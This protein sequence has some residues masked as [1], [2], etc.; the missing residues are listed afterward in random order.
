MSD[1][2]APTDDDLVIPTSMEDD[3]EDTDPDEG[4]E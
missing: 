1:E 3:D 2:H 4:D